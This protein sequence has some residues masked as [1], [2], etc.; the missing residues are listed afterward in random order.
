MCHDFITVV[1]SSRS[2]QICLIVV[3]SILLLPWPYAKDILILS[4]ALGVNFI[5]TPVCQLTA[6]HF[7][8]SSPLPF[9]DNIVKRLLQILVKCMY[10]ETNFGPK[11]RIF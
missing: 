6:I 4:L 11:Y 3:F 7:D 1:F 5:L 2:R 10:R 9:Y 8:H